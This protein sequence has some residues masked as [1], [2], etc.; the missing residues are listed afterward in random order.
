L[1]EAPQSL[2]SACLRP[3]VVL[4]GQTCPVAGHYHEAFWVLVGT[5]TPVLLVANVVAAGQTMT[6]LDFPKGAFSADDPVQTEVLGQLW[7]PFMVVR[8]R[9]LN[10]GSHPLAVFAV[11]CLQAIINIILLLNALSSLED[12][13]DFI[14]TGFAIWLVVLSARSSFNASRHS[15][16]RPLAR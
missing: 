6:S 4:V 16:N 2:L 7:R 14:G 10:F 9:L 8:A 3:A 12:E 5:A 11:A 15:P 1:R 13:R